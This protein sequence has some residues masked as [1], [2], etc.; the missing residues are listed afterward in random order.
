MVVQPCQP[1]VIRF[2]WRSLKVDKNAFGR[3]A[4]VIFEQIIFAK[5]RPH[6]KKFFSRAHFDDGTCEQIVKH[7]EKIIE[8]NGLEVPHVIQVII[9]GQQVIAAISEVA[10]QFVP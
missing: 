3:A 5:L 9:A 8:L 7:L 1:Q 6:L 2:S 4:Q 10:K